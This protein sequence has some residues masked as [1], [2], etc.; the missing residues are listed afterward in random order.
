MSLSRRAFATGLAATGLAKGRHQEDHRAP[1]IA[2]PSSESAGEWQPKVFDN[3][4]LAT[5]GTLAEL[6]IPRTETPGAREALVHQHL[7]RILSDSLEAIRSKIL[8]GLWW[9]D[10][11]CLRL[12]AKPFNDLAPDR[13]MQILL[14]A[15]QSA[16]AVRLN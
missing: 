16:A 9:L 15:H 6:I 1:E 7:D 11:Y 14:A 4:Q 3:H 12:A 5:V 2:L 8:E 13:Q 10:G